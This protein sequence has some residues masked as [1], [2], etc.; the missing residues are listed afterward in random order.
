[1]FLTDKY[2]NLDYMIGDKAS[3]TGVDCAPEIIEFWNSREASEILMKHFKSGTDIIVMADVD[4]DGLSSAYLMIQFIRYLGLN[5]KVTPCINSKREH[6]IKSETVDYFNKFNRDSLVII[7]DSSTNCIDDI[8]K[9]NHDVIVIDHHDLS[10]PLEEMSGATVGGN[11]MIINNVFP[12]NKLLSGENFPETDTFSACMAVLEFIRYFTNK[13]GLEDVV[14]K[15]DM[16]SMAVCSLFTDVINTDTKRNLYYVNRAFSI[17]TYEP[18][19]KII[20]KELNAY[21]GKLNKSF[22]LYKMAPVFNAAIR[23]GASGEALNVLVNFP[24]RVKNLSRYSSL[25]KEVL[26]KINGLEI[27]HD[28]YVA[29]NLTQN[30]ISHNYSG[31]IASKLVGKYRKSSIAY[32]EIG[33]GL[34]R[35]SFRG[36]SDTI[37]YRKSFKNL[38]YFAEG[39]RAA[40]GL[41]L[42]VDQIE[43]AMNEVLHEERTERQPY[44]TYGNLLESR[45]GK[46]H[47]N[48]I[49]AFK[50]E[51]NIWKLGLINSKISG[52]RSINLITTIYDLSLKADL[53]TYKRYDF[54]G[55]ECI[56]FEEIESPQVLLYIEYGVNLKVYVRNHWN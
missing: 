39:H 27:E 32:S 34:V 23:A 7:V 37:E 33:N 51:G 44:L 42:P 21:I 6:G 41:K 8:R 48:D 25:Q 24:S 5:N 31:V 46:Y 54:H 20:L 15:R 56:A 35:C 9:I 52:D 2:K 3:N 53:G 13:Y 19:L 26:G 18:A 17:D 43:L 30:N 28:N 40:F 4:F 1:M 10:R 55:I 29:L 45:H 14:F 47:I 38:G 16:Y 36:L 50:K 12:C 11:Y 22:I 49:E